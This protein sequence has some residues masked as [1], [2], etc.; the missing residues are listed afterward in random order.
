M[1]TAKHHRPGWTNQPIV[2]G[3]VTGWWG[4]KAQPPPQIFDVWAMDLGGNTPATG[5][6]GGKATAHGQPCKWPG[7]PP[8]RRRQGPAQRTRAGQTAWP[9]TVAS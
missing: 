6:L 9:A 1:L 8:P 4:G 2:K 7:P 3:R 5:G